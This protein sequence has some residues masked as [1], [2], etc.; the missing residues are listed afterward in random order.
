MWNRLQVEKLPKNLTSKLNTIKKMNDE[1]NICYSKSELEHIYSHYDVKH[2]YC[3]LHTEGSTLTF[4]ETQ[5][6]Y[7][8]AI[9]N[10]VS[11]K[12]FMECSNLREAILYVKKMSSST[13]LLTEDFILTLHRILGAGLLDHTMA[14][15]Y[16]TIRNMIGR[17][18]YET[19]QI[20]Q[21]S[22]LMKQLVD[23]SNSIENPIVRAAWTSYNFVSIHPF[24]DYN[25]R[26]SRLLETFI[27][28]SSDYPTVYL[29]EEKI[30]EYMTILRNGQESEDSTNVKYIDFM[31]ELVL[32]SL[33]I[34]KG[35]PS[36][37]QQ[38]PVSKITKF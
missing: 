27:L 29:P 1:I 26:L 25:G 20:N 7:D 16:R 23:I 17:G 13:S 11:Y 34:A 22:K 9:P 2:T 36:P 10:N 33:Q 24:V 19:A 5:A 8:K 37:T 14:G 12:E 3:S 18:N 35:E 4:E 38:K 21:I 15:N 32:K 28:T 30:S 31:S 6:I